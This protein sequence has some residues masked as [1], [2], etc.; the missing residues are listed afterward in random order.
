MAGTRRS[1]LAFTAFPIPFH[2][3]SLGENSSQAAPC[4]KAHVSCAVGSNFDI[5]SEAEACHQVS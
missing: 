3:V 5:M 4:S 2:R 1:R